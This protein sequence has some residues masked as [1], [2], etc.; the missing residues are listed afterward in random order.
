MRQRPRGLPELSFLRADAAHV[1]ASCAPRASERGQTC[2]GLRTSDLGFFFS[3]SVI[4]FWLGP[5]GAGTERAFLRRSTRWPFVLL[6]LCQAFRQVNESHWLAG[7]MMPLGALFK[8]R[9]GAGGVATPLSRALCAE[10]RAGEAGSI[11]A[12]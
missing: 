10:R 8:R 4:S 7:G 5:R 12:S 3:R 6:H 11:R 2:A 9:A 1:F